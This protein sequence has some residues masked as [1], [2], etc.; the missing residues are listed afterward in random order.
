ML[1]EQITKLSIENFGPYQNAEFNFS[2]GL[3]L[4]RGPNRSGKTWLLRA[5]AAVLYN[6]GA[7]NDDDT[8]D[9]VRYE[10]ENGVKAPH[11]KIRIDLASGSWV[12]RYRDKSTNKYTICKA[13]GTPQE[14]TAIGRGFYSPVGE[15][16][17]IFPVILDGKTETNPNIRLLEDPRFF[18]IGESPQRQDAILTRLVG[19]DIIEQAANEAEID[20]RQL[21]QKINQLK[22][23]TSELSNE[24]DKYAVLPSM[25]RQLGIAA[26]G[27]NA[28]SK[29]RASIHRARNIITQKNE[30]LSKHI[31]HLNKIV[32]DAKP[33]IARIDKVLE[34]WDTQQQLAKQIPRLE[35]K[36]EYFHR[37]L[38]R[39]KHLLEAATASST[40][41]ENAANYWR[42]R[43]EEQ[44]S[45]SD[46]ENKIGRYK[47]KARDAKNE[48]QS[49]L[50][51]FGICPL[52]GQEIKG[53]A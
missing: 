48:R 20:R 21:V 51:G 52:C 31:D 33:L 29:L 2:D 12:E 42:K 14:H 16:T 44:A 19:I 41:A 36:L 10:T 6:W 45:L 35:S 26:D 28:W 24:L 49:M 53:V 40:K 25:V 15:V 37:L 17:G 39:L 38:P 9:E 4:I 46:L 30:L 11:F 27:L 13:G 8:L 1:N 43:Q 34:L 23:N 18:I 7:F 3:N 5:L 50:R 22:D 47:D 32:A